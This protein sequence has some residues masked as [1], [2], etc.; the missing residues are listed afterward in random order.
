M[1]N[2]TDIDKI[3]PRKAKD[4]MDGDFALCLAYLEVENDKD[5]ACGHSDDFDYGMIEGLEHAQ[6]SILEML[7]IATL[8]DIDWEDVKKAPMRA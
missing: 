4:L 7:D 1:S 6:N 2:K 5:M 8:G 3:K